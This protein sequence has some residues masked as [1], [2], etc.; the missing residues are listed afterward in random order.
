MPDP[1]SDLLV[2]S[3]YDAHEEVGV[4]TDVL[5]GGVHAKVGAKLKRELE[6]LRN[7]KR[8]RSVAAD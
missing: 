8:A 2:V 3:G 4:A 1:G 5:G 6:Q 7:R